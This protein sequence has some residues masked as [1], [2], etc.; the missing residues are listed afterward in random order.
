MGRAVPASGR[1]DR[2][3]EVAF[4]LLGYLRLARAVSAGA[5]GDFGVGAHGTRAGDSLLEG[6]VD[7]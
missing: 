1:T 6:V 2:S 3:F 4:D 7:H 5:Q